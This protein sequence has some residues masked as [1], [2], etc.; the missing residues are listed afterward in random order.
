MDIQRNH[1][2]LL[3]DFKKMIHTNR[4]SNLL[5]FIK[6]QMSSFFSSRLLLALL[7]LVATRLVFAQNTLPEFPR[8][9]IPQSEISLKT[10]F[11]ESRC[12]KL[13]DGSSGDCSIPAAVSAP[14]AQII[15][16]SVKAVSNPGQGAFSRTHFNQNGVRIDFDVYS[17]FPQANSEF[18]PYVQ[19]QVEIKTPVKAVCM[20]SIRWRENFEVPSL[21]CAGY[22]DKEN[23][24]VK[25]GL[26]LTQVLAPQN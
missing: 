19:I 23:E 4:A 26:S 2:S 5:V 6:K 16:L 12:A 24:F 8:N 18:S 25:W 20:Q 22:I 17:V 14:L 11:W 15:K 21:V 10:L 3:Q 1:L 13:D 9:P 7:P